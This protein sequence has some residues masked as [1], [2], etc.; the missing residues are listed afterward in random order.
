MRAGPGRPIGRCSRSSGTE[1][2]AT[3]GLPSLRMPSPNPIVA[4]LALVRQLH[5][6]RASPDDQEFGVQARFAQLL[7]DPALS[8]QA[9]AGFECPA[10]PGPAGC[11]GHHG[12]SN[13][14]IRIAAWLPASSRR[15]SRRCSRRRLACHPVPPPRPVAIVACRPPRTSQCHSQPYN[16]QVPILTE[17]TAEQ[18]PN[19]CLVRF[20]GMVRAPPAVAAAPRVCVAVASRM[21]L[22]WR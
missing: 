22:A 12:M 4:P 21:H 15:C 5:A 14:A 6:A 2:W 8:A 10:G 19:Q 16:H 13:W 20:R 17:D 11:M 1:I 3:G 9:S 18:L 7:A